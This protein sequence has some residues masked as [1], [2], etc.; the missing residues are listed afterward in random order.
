[1]R[2]QAIVDAEPVRSVLSSEVR[3]ALAP[4]KTYRELVAD[5][6]HVGVWRM[7]R[8]PLS[9]LSFIASAVPIMAVQRI[10]LALFAFSI[11]SFT[12]VVVIQIA[13]GA[14][15]IASVR[16]RRLGMAHALDLWF[17]GHVPYS[18]SLL[19]VAAV[20]AATPY[21]SLDGLIALAA[22]PAAWTAWV[23]AAFC[24][25]VLGTSRAGARWRAAAHFVVTWVIAF[26]LV[27]LSAGG[28]F[29]ITRS[30]LRFFE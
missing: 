6:E 16:P 21:A 11:A 15:I 29:Q 30:I 20:F 8:R 19:V 12:F 23:V 28:W 24:R 27:S 10:T 9:V 13:V 14:G 7:L 22:L 18:L 17:G 1:M 4:D 26:E 25:Q 3:I 2:A 5:N